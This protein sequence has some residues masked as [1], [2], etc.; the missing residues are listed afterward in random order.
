MIRK[1]LIGMEL[2]RRRTERKLRHDGRLRTGGHPYGYACQHMRGLFVPRDELG[3][4]AMA[5][6]SNTEFAELLPHPENWL[7]NVMSQH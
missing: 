2:K 3:G 5:D 7:S 1:S 6:L 4:R